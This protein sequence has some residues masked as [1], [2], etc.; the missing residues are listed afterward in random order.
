LNYKEG[1]SFLSFDGEGAG[2]STWQDNVT[3]G[4][5]KSY[6][7]EFLLQKKVGKFSGWAGYTLSWT[8]WQF[9]ELNFGKEFFPR[10]DR[11][12]D[13]SLVGIYEINKRMT[14]SAT[15][16]Y[17]TGNA[18]TIPIVSYSAGLDNITGKSGGSFGIFQD[19]F[20]N[21]RNVS[22]YGDRNSFRAEPFH[23]LDIALQV[24]KQKKRHERTWEFGFYNAYNRRNP[25]FYNITT[26]GSQPNA[27][28]QNQSTKTVLQRVSL[29]PII[30]SVTYSFKF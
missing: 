30:P 20:L 7:A 22:E 26:E 3:A 24:R 29:F 28:G 12:H 14:L 17:G 11:R 6:G 5:G 8:I 9:A 25:F 21:F 13:I 15:W 19:N 18:L 16:V 4:R 10:Y 27:N 2:Q 1:A 23:R